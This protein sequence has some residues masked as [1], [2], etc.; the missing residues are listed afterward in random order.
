VEG[1]VFARLAGTEDV[2]LGRVR[3]ADGLPRKLACWQRSQS[4]P[5]QW[6]AHFPSGACRAIRLL[7]SG[8][9]AKSRDRRGWPAAYTNEVK[10]ALIT[11]WEDLF[12]AADVTL[13]VKKHAVMKA[14]PPGSIL[15]GVEE[16]WQ[17]RGKRRTSMDSIA[18]DSHTHYAWARVEDERGQARKER[19]IDH[20]RGALRSFFQSCEP[21]SLVAV[22]TIGNWYW[23]V[24]EIEAAR[25][26]PQ[27]VHAGRASTRWNIWGLT[28]SIEQRA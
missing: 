28:R 5:R 19:R 20:A 27:L 10:A 24:D 6:M 11:V 2:D 18:F 17:S 21:G 4:G 1:A 26:V 22:E 12:Q 9:N 3:G 25:M 14:A 16:T 7:G 8:R 23:N 13:P 15:H